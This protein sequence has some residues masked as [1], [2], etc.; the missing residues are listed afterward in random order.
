[1]A[2][3]AAADLVFSAHSQQPAA[4]PAVYR[5]VKN[6]NAECL[7]RIQK[8][9]TTRLSKWNLSPSADA[10]CRSALAR[11]AV[12]SSELFIGAPK[13]GDL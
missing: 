6:A 8:W 12:H 11:A 9:D 13:M 5:I 2:Q 3:V 7:R 4:P 1:M 10:G